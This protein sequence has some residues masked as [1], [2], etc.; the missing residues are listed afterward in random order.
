MLP[1]PP[2]SPAYWGW[3]WGDGDGSDGGGDGGSSSSNGDGSS[4]SGPTIDSKIPIG[5]SD[6]D[7]GYRFYTSVDFP[8]TSGGTHSV[9]MMIDSGSST[10][11]IC[12][13]SVINTITKSAEN[14][15][16]CNLYGSAAQGSGYS[17]P[18]VEGSATVSGNTQSL[19]SV[20][21]AFMEYHQGMP[22]QSGYQ[23]IFGI[24]YKGMDQAYTASGFSDTSTYTAGMQW[25]QE[26]EQSGNSPADYKNPLM[27][28][29]TEATGSNSHMWGLYYSGNAGANSGTLYL[30]ADATTNSHYNSGTTTAVITPLYS[31]GD[32]GVGEWAYYNVKVTKFVVGS[33]ESNV[34]SDSDSEDGYAQVVIDTGTPI[35][36]LPYDICVALQNN[37][38]QSL[39][40]HIIDS[41]N[42]AVP[43]NLGTGRML[44]TGGPDRSPLYS[45]ASQPG[46]SPPQMYILG[47]PIWLT[48]YTV[49]DVDQNLMHWVA[50]SN[51]YTQLPSGYWNWWS[52]PSPPPP[53]PP[54]APSIG[55]INSEIPIGSSLMDGGWRFST[56]VAFPTSGTNIVL[57][58]M[59]DSGSSTAAVCNYDYFT[60]FTK[61]DLAEVSCNLYGSGNEGYQGPFVQGTMILGGDGEAGNAGP[62]PSPSPSSSNSGNGDSDGGSGRRTPQQLPNTYYAFMQ[63]HQ[64]M[65]CNGGYDGIFGIAF[66]GL[67]TS[68]SNTNYA[69]QATSYSSAASWCQTTEQKGY[70]AAF[71]APLIQTLTEGTGSNSHLWGLY[72]QYTTATTGDNTGTLYLGDA[73]KSNSHFTTSTPKV[74]KLYNAEGGSYWNF[75]NVQITKFSVGSVVYQTGTYKQSYAQGMIDT[76]TPSLSLPSSIIK[77]LQDDPSTPLMMYVNGVVGDVVSINLGTGNTLNNQCNQ[78]LQEAQAYAAQYVIGWPLWMSQYTVIDVENHQMYWVE[79]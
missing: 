63:Y 17:G 59:I 57:D 25:C 44:N 21:Y 1:A 23:G 22:C 55:V 43:I 71:K 30:G 60:S 74:A 18:F 8:T 4:S 24:A 31:A 27:Q 12:D 77:A 51:S 9:Q 52:P 11:A 19:P 62:S 7:G 79:K 5:C 69:F 3:G 67:D 75:Y 53:A 61:T 35:F 76:G 32:F 56:K 40:M 45:P 14:T 73:A 70:N 38:S 39:I 78:C 68:Y 33:S 64:S 54:P 28:T 37:P 49:M 58:L 66:Q 48:Q 29:L 26:A 6:F 13:Y 10:A 46:T 41:S 34:G 65:P 15:V 2:P 72:Y 20:K 50:N 42:S 16:S 36:Q 47:W